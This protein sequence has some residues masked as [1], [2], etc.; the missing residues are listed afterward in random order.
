M[1]DLSV[2]VG[3]TP[4]YQCAALQ[5]HRRTPGGGASRLR[6]T[7][8]RNDIAILRLTRSVAGIDHVAGV[9]VPP[10]NQEP[11]IGAVLQTVVWSRTQEEVVEPLR[12]IPLK[13]MNREKCRRALGSQTIP[14]SQICTENDDGGPCSGDGGGPLVLRRI[15]GDYLVGLSSYGT[16]G[17]HPG[18]ADVFTKVSHYLDWILRTVDSASPASSGSASGS[19][20]RTTPSPSIGS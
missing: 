20:R 7:R 10:L 8:I 18:T 9:K 5:H 17:C 13:I 4:A 15:N 11:P 3:T 19:Q 2:V 1:G 6:Q 16:K 14:S 12:T